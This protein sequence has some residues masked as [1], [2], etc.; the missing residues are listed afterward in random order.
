LFSPIPILAR[1]IDDLGIVALIF[2]GTSSFVF[3]LWI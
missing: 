2:P 3:L 1:L